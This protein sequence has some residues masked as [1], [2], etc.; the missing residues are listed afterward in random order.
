MMTIAEVGKFF[1]Q[2][3]RLEKF[4]HDFSNNGLQACFDARRACRKIAFAVDASQRSID[5][6]IAMQADLLVV[7]HG[8]SWGDD[9]RRLNGMAGRRFGSM[10]KGD[11]ALYAVHLPLDAHEIYGN[12]ATLADLVNLEQRQMFFAYHGMEI[13][14]TGQCPAA[15]PLQ[16][17]AQMAAIGKDYT[18]YAA[19]QAGQLVRKAAIISGGGGMDGLTAAI[20]AGADVLI[21]GEFGHSMYHIVQ[22]NFTH[23]IALGHYNSE[24]HGVHNL[25]KIAEKELNIPGYFLDIPTG[26]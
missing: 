17:L 14:I 11:L 12:N 9:P 3:L 6:A 4:A 1:D 10:F 15:I 19:P 25:L 18:V 2:L 13:G 24:V 5:Q 8:L 21:T 26:L 7:H 22:E 23:V 16:E 20:E